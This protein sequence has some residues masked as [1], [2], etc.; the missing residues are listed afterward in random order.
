MKTI[1]INCSRKK[2]KIQKL[3]MT[4]KMI[5]IP[6]TFTHLLDIRDG[7]T[8]DEAEDKCESLRE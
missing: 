7:G 5:N 1:K 8:V 3:S 2:G 6:M 4:M